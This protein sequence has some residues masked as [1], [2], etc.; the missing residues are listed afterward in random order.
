MISLPLQVFD[1]VRSPEP[2]MIAR[3]FGTAAVLLLLVLGLFLVARLIGGK[4]P[5]QLSDAQRRRVSA[6]S[7]RDLIRMTPS[8]PQL[9][10]TQETTRVP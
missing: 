3:G 4:G 8:T 5:G 7:Q 6:Q 9:P 1:F 10:P 2:N